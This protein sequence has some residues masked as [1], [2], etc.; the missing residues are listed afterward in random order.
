MRYGCLSMPIKISYR[1]FRIL[2]LLSIL[3]IAACD[4]NSGQQYQASAKPSENATLP[5]QNNSALDKV[6]ATWEQSTYNNVLGCSINDAA[7]IGAINTKEGLSIKGFITANLT[8]KQGAHA[9]MLV[10]SDTQD[11]GYVL[12]N[13]KGSDSICVDQK[14]LDIEFNKNG[15]FAAT[16]IAFDG[17]YTDARCNF[18]ARYGEEI[19]GSFEKVSSGLARTGFKIDYQAKLPND[20]VVTVMSGNNKAYQLTTNFRTGSTVVTGVGYAEFTAQ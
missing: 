9:H 19:C 20:N 1:L 12:V 8:H 11:Y 13:P 14:V 15:N 7:A 3:L 10:Y 2:P 5:R 4:K 6:P 16:K 18:T 17:R